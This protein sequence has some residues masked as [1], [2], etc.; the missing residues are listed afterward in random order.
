MNAEGYTGITESGGIEAMR[1]EGIK[2]PHWGVQPK[3]E[4]LAELGTGGIKR[5]RYKWPKCGHVFV[6]PE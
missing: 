2:C 4:N 1:K 6:M 5:T 3:T